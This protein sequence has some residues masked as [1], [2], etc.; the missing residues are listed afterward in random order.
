MNFNTILVKIKNSRTT[1]FELSLDIATIKKI[2]K[3][4]EVTG[5]LCAGKLR[6]C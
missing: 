6:V 5:C 4:V 3:A 1:L 2:R